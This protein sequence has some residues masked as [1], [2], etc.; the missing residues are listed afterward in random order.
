MTKDEFL[1]GKIF[2]YIDHGQ[3]YRHYFYNKKT[4]TIKSPLN[5]DVNLVTSILDTGF[6]YRAFIQEKKGYLPTDL[7]T[8]FDKIEMI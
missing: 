3:D 5:I 7:F 1:K 2:F 8:N 6:F 4:K